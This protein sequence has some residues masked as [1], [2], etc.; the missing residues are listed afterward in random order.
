MENLYLIF[1]KD[2]GLPLFRYFLSGMGYVL[3]MD[4]ITLARYLKFFEIGS[5]LV[6]GED[7]PVLINGTEDK[8]TRLL[9]EHIGID[10]NGA[11]YYR[12]NKN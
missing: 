8:A 10:Y 11:Q 12:G 7:N 1:S 2:C 9:F 3:W 4:S 6:Q 5:D